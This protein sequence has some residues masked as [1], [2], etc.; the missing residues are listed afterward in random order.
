MG[1]CVSLGTDKPSELTG[2]RPAG[3]R[4]CYHSVVTFK[5]ALLGQGHSGVERC[6]RA[7]A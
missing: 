2:S 3:E 6:V 5:L 7:G 1:F 4:H